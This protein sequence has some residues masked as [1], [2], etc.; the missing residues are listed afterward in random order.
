MAQASKLFVEPGQVQSC[1]VGSLA[2]QKMFAKDLDKSLAF[3]FGNNVVVFRPYWSR[4]D[5]FAIRVE[6]FSCMT[7]WHVVKRACVCARMCVLSVLSELVEPLVTASA[8][9]DAHRVWLT[10]TFELAAQSEFSC[11]WLIGCENC[12]RVSCVLARTC[13]YLKGCCICCINHQCCWINCRWDVVT[14]G[15]FELYVQLDGCFVPD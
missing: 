9:I 15:V 8:S 1:S 4:G 14:I 7:W 10:S 2:S 11:F 13:Y 12:C 3:S 5:G 6:C